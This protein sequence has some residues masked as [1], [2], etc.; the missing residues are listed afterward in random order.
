MAK[1]KTGRRSSVRANRK[2]AAASGVPSQSDLEPLLAA[3]HESR[4]DDMVRGAR[5]F[6]RRWPDQAVGWN[7]LA[8]GLRATGQLDEAESACR[9]A[10]Q[11][12]PANAEAHNNLGN[13]LRDRGDLEAAEAAYRRAL[14]HKPTLI[15]AGYNLSCVLRTAGRLYEAAALLRTV[16][17]QRPEEFVYHCALGATLKEMGEPEEARDTL[18]RALSIRPDHA[19]THNKLGQVLHELSRFEEAKAS[20][21][22]AIELRPELQEIHNN[23]GNLL[24]TTGEREQAIASLRRALALDPDYVNGWYNLAMTKKFVPDDPDIAALEQQ[25]ARPDLVDAARM[26]FHFALGKALV[27]IEADADQVFAQYLEGCRLKRTTFDYDPDQTDRLF[28]R[29]AQCFPREWFDALPAVG[30]A[31]DAPIFVVGMPRSGTTLVEQ[32]LASHARVHGAGERNDLGHLVKAKNESS[33]H[34]Y[35]EWLADMPVD[36]L[37]LLG[38]HYRRRVIDPV[39][40]S[41]RVV[42]KMPENFRYLGLIVAALPNARIV[43]IRRDPLDTCLSCFMHLFNA[44]QPFCYDLTELGRYYRAYAG[45]MDHWRNNL[46]KGRMLE[47]EYEQLVTD[48]EPW[49]RRLLAHCGLEWDPACLEF[50]TSQRLV[51]TASTLQVRQPINRSAVGRWRRYRDHLQPLIEALGPLASHATKVES[52]SSTQPT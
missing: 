9:R 32:I 23:L 7:L 13:V 42:D 12:D 11:V 37:S 31:T 19:E 22:R 45:L 49:A 24:R 34:Q 26:H 14:A 33:G 52:S 2:T 51:K 47:L 48:P 35:P 3:Y 43:H 25:L 18:E 15:E 29:I 41:D 1:R 50:H 16:V 46:P 30:D 6:T 20:F 17:A 36:E 4:F 28:A 27:D 5:R 40:S 44:W 8:E 10:L 38:A 21:E 39:E